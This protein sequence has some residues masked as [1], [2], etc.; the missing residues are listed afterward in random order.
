MKVY[1]VNTIAPR[2]LGQSYLRPVSPVTIDYTLKKVEKGLLFQ[3]NYQSPA[4]SE[5]LRNNR[6]QASNGLIIAASEFPEF[7]ESKNTV[8]LWGSDKTRNGKLDATSFTHNF[9][10]DNAYNMLKQAM[11]EF[12]EYV[13]SLQPRFTPSVY[14]CVC[15]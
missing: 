14:N 12:V 10:R 11:L 1:H 6:F 7:K 5:F 8:Y 4:V 15:F 3:V 13:Q 2:P 9:K